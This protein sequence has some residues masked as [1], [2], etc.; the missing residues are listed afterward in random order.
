MIEDQAIEEGTCEEEKEVLPF[1]TQGS[2]MMISQ[3]APF[4][5]SGSVDQT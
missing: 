5:I 4:A 2:S 3:K 1:D